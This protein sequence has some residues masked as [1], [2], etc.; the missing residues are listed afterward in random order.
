MVEL[1]FVRSTETTGFNDGANIRLSTIVDMLDETAFSTSMSLDMAN[2]LFEGSAIHDTLGKV[3]G[4]LG[5]NMETY[6][7]TSL[8]QAISMIVGYDQQLYYDIICIM[9]ALIEVADNT[10]KNNFIRMIGQIANAEVAG[11]TTYESEDAGEAPAEEP[12]AEET[13]VSD[14]ET[15]NVDGT[16]EPSA[17]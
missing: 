4:I 3:H 7:P 16:E 12:A 15:K 5:A 6:D 10:E 2:A 11:R 1:N 9:R 13:E 14:N 17:E 8:I